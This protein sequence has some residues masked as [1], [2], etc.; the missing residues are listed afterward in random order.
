MLIP[1]YEKLIVIHDKFF[2]KDLKKYGYM[3]SD[4]TKKGGKGKSK[5]KTIKI[6]L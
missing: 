2:D 4:G 1:I 5:Q 6:I 3:F